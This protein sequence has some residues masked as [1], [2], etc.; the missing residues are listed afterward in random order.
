M[1]KGRGRSFFW[2]QLRRPR[3]AVRAAVTRLRLSVPQEV[4][5]SR[6]FNEMS[7]EAVAFVLQSDQLRMDEAD[8]LEKVT[9]WATVNSVSW[10]RGRRRT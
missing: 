4:F 10:R 2:D 6:G 8:I 3:N 7:E 5:K 9:E 1:C